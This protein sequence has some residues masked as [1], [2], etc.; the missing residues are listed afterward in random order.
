M[1]DD[2]DFYF[3]LVD[4]RPASIFV[5]L[6]IAKEAPVADHSHMAYVSVTMR[7]PREDGLS[8]NAE[9]DDLVAIEETLTEQTEQDGAALF[10]GRSTSDGKRDF[11]YYVKDPDRFDKT[12]RA[13]M[14]IY[15]N[16]TFETSARED[17]DWAVYFDFLH[18]S[19]DDMQ[20]IQNRR[21]CHQLE[22]HGDNLNSL[23]SIDH[24]VFLPSQIA[25][26]DFVAYVQSI[27]FTVQQSAGEAAS[28]GRFSIAFA[29]DDQPAQID[30]VV[31]L[32]AAKV[33]ELGGTYDGWGCPIQT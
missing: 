14:S 12:A 25:Q 6:G 28:D 17:K 30:E 21:V 33:S 9:F 7:H 5:D 32:L 31:I 26:S 18:P 13:V 11:Y 27:G 4:D 3:L 19:A 2:W 24:F 10:V 23:R 15:A 20:R 22:A 16:Y 8:S 29:R 1:S